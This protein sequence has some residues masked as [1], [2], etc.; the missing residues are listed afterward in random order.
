MRLLR[1]RYDE[2]A[3]LGEVEKRL[4]QKAVVLGADLKLP[5][6]WAPEGAEGG[7]GRV[8]YGRARSGDGQ[9]S[10]EAL[11]RQAALAPHV[12]RLADLEQRTQSGYW[13]LRRR[14]AS[15][16]AAAAATTQ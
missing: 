15:A 2:P 6:E 8:Q 1:G 9:M 12:A 7:D 14:F 4:G 11:A 5:P 13:E 3:L 10:A 16:A